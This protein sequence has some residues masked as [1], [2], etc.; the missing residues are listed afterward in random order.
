[1][2]DEAPVTIIFRPTRLT[3]RVEITSPAVVVALNI[4]IVNWKKEKKEKKKKVVLLYTITRVVRVCVDSQRRQQAG[5]LGN[6][7]SGMVK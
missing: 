2:P 4:E 1:M 6:G 3:P 7:L 5:L